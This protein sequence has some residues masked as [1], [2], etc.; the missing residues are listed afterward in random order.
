MTV[1]LKNTRILVHTAIFPWD[2]YTDEEVID[3]D[4]LS[5][6]SGNQ[7]FRWAVLNLFDKVSH[8]NFIT[9]WDFS[10]NTEL[11][12]LKYDYFVLP[13]S[14]T[15]R[16]GSD[17]ELIYL[18]DIMNQIDAKVLLFG[19]GGMFSREGFYKFS[20]E[21][22]IKNFIETAMG[23]TNIIGLRDNY[24]YKYLTEYLGYPEEKFSIIGCPS[25]TYKGYLQE[26]QAYYKIHTDK[27]NLIDQEFKIAVN[28]IAGDY[29]YHWASFI[30]KVL[31]ENQKADV[32]LQDIDE[33]RL[34][35][36]G[37]SLVDERR[38]DLLVGDNQHFAYVEG[39]AKFIADPNRWISELKD[40][41]FSLGTR[42]HGAIAAALAG[43]PVMIIATD[44]NTAGLAEYH[45][46][47]YIWDYELTEKTSVEELY[48]RACFEMQAYYD[49]FD[50][51]YDKYINFIAQNEI[52]LDIL[53]KSLIPKRLFN[54]NN[55]VVGN[56]ISSWD[57]YLDELSP[58][59]ELQAGESIEFKK[60]KK[61]RKGSKDFWA[62]QNFRTKSL[63]QLNHK[64]RVTVLW[65]GKN[66]EFMLTAQDGSEVVKISDE[67][68]EN[69]QEVVFEV[70]IKN[71]DID[72]IGFSE[73]FKTG[74][75]HH[76]GIEEID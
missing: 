2:S 37:H 42:I 29:D 18:T 51:S 45:H 30:D 62:W 66:K 58:Y 47:P 28:Y 38:H 61:A 9:T 22:L 60:N 31:F 11:Q 39:R 70:E 27:Y 12:K 56:L 53:N 74:R 6:N 14:D 4:W 75:V 48:Y 76:I 32:F 10:H 71:D 36:Y 63:L 13:M 52:D 23:K 68:K 49:Y 54:Y 59:F 7:L 34:V 33:A 73:N 46:L 17:E 16:E 57:V 40:Y 35:E 43:L 44:S 19:L 41:K 24:S 64:Y 26:K 20:N 67:I 21:K 50:E 1:K 15:L 55:S 8:E 5:G 72:H 25:V 3:M 69:G 65:E